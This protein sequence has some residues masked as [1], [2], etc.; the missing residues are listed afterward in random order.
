MKKQI[1]MKQMNNNWMVHR[2]KR[3]L[4]K[5]LNQ[6]LQNQELVQTQTTPSN[7]I[8]LNSYS[9]KCNNHTSNLQTQKLELQYK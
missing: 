3:E 2:K 9:T 7:I 5:E 8:N 6:T 1:K 4:E